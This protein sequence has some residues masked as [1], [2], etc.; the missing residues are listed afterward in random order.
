MALQCCQNTNGDNKSKMVKAN[1]RVAN[2]RQKTIYCTVR[3]NTAQRMMRESGRNR[4]QKHR[5]G[6]CKNLLHLRPP[7]RINNIE[8]RVFARKTARQRYDTAHPDRS[9][10]HMKRGR[11]P[12]LWSFLLVSLPR[13]P[14]WRNPV[15][16]R[17]ATSSQS[18]GWLWLCM[19]CFMRTKFPH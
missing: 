12:G 14:F 17:Q 7:Q 18:R 1:D 5:R 9:S 13:Q 19:A 10:F 15:V 6:K 11:S 8:I 3:H 4:C 16:Y 2:P